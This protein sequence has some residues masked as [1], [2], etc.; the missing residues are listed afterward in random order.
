[1][2]RCSI[3][4][5]SESRN[6]LNPASSCRLLACDILFILSPRCR[7]P[8]DFAILDIRRVVEEYRQLDAA[9]PELRE[10]RGAA[11]SRIQI[12]RRVIGR[13]DHQRVEEFD[14][15]QLAKPR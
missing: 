1:M 13:I 15:R 5:I 9:M 2:A 11:V 7:L 6:Y 8:F 3:S 10:E 4:A 12:G 14:Q